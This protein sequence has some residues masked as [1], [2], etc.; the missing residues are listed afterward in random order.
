MKL[1]AEYI[2]EKYDRDIIYDDD[3]Y[4]SYNKLDNNTI[5]I[6]TLFVSKEARRSGKGQEL[7]QSL[8]ERET[9]EI[10]LCNIDMKGKDYQGAFAAIVDGGGYSLLEAEWEEPD[11]I[12]L[13]REVIYD[14]EGKEIRRGR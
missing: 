4:I 13:F 12:Y 5:F 14:K 10:I 8:I 7:E 3:G 11:K 6:H 2:K 9:P 1:Y